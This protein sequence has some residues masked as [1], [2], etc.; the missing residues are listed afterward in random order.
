VQA[1]FSGHF[2]AK[3]FLFRYWMTVGRIARELWW[4]NQEISPVD[5]IPSWLSMLIYLLGDEQQTR[6]WSQF[7]DLVSPHRH[8]EQQRRYHIEMNG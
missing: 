7:R 5:I 4:T 1:K 6:W 3:F 2:F 8:E